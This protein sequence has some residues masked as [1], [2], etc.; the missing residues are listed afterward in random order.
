MNI[1]IMIKLKK[2]KLANILIDINNI[3]NNYKINYNNY[4]I[5]IKKYNYYNIIIL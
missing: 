5:K 2:L 1:F 3:N 4:K